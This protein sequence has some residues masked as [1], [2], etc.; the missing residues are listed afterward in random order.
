M[1]AGRVFETA[2]LNTSIDAIFLKKA[3][4]QANSRWPKK[5]TKSL[6]SSEYL[7]EGKGG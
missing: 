1:F 6:S 4:K 3:Q 5:V 7:S 2:G